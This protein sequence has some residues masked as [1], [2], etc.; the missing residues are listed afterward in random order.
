MPRCI[1]LRSVIATT[2]QEDR[3]TI[4]KDD[5]DGYANEDLILEAFCVT[6]SEGVDTKRCNMVVV[7]DP[8]QDKKSLVQLFGCVQRKPYQADIPRG[9]VLLLAHLDPAEYESAGEELWRTPW[10]V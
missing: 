1:K 8:I 6:L 3:G 7:V 4:L 9:N 2:S 10:Q 5:P